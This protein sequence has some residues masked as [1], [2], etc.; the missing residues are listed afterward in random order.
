MRP[1]TTIDDMLSV[2]MGTTVGLLEI[3]EVIEKDYTIDA[4]DDKRREQYIS[5]IK[6]A[7][8]QLEKFAE[9]FKN[10]AFAKWVK[11]HIKF[12]EEDLKQ[13]L[14]YEELSDR[15]RDHL[16]QTVDYRTNK[17]KNENHQLD[18]QLLTKNYKESWNVG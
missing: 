14:Y 1:T 4:F 11:Q 3:R 7:I 18:K 10:S 12:L 8:K 6:E 16:L 15:L 2:T 5:T 9:D 17:I 13:Q